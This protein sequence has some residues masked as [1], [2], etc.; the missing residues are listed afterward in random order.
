MHT[1]NNSFEHNEDYGED[2]AYHNIGLD[3]VRVTEATALVAGRWL[4][5]GKR[6][7]AHRAATEAMYEAL[8]KV[9]IDGYIVIGEEGRLKEP[10]PL[11]TGCHVGT[12]NGPKVDVV[13]DPIEGPRSVVH[14]HPGA[15]ARS[16]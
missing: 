16:R 14:G 3:L 15:E 10:T 6:D 7:E 1:E 2:Y 5:L 9:N 13:V 11:Q 12:G 8:S 4:G